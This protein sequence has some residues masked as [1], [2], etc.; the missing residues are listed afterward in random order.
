MKFLILSHILFREIIPPPPTIQF[1]LP[2]FILILALAYRYFAVI[3]AEYSNVVHF[4]YN[5][6]DDDDLKHKYLK[7]IQTSRMF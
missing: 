7:Q 4:V 5:H 6:D 1:N 2:P 3:E